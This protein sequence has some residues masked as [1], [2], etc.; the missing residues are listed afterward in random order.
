M[1]CTVS[2]EGRRVCMNCTVSEEGRRVCMNCT[3]W[4]LQ[5]HSCTVCTAP[6]FIILPYVK[7]S[8]CRTEIS[9][10]EQ[11]LLKLSFYKST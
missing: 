2:G 5:S 6:Y 4:F 10:F 8:Y 9:L 1:N 3:S 7:Y 11:I